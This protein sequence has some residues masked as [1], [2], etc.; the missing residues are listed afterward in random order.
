MSNVQLTEKDMADNTSNEQN[1]YK[2]WHDAK[3]H[4]C[5]QFIMRPSASRKSGDIIVAM[6]VLILS[7]SMTS[8]GYAEKN[9][10][11]NKVERALMDYQAFLENITEIKELATERLIPLLGEWKMLD[12]SVYAIVHH[13]EIHNGV[14]GNDSVYWVLRDSINGK[15]LELTESQTRTLTDYLDVILFLNE[16]ELD[17]LS[18]S[19]S[20]SAHKF[21]ASMD[22]VPVFGYDNRNTV[23]KYE[24]VLDDAL[25]KGFKSRNDVFMFL[26]QEDRAFRSFLTHLSSYGDIP[27]TN[28]RDKSSLLMKRLVELGQEENPLLTP[29]E[30][31]ILLTMRNNR[32]LLQNAVQCADDIHKMKIRNATQASAYMWMLLQPWMTF[33]KTSYALMNEEQIKALYALAAKAPE[34]ITGLG[35]PEFPIGTDE[36]ATLLINTIITNL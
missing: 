24:Q 13:A 7:L 30:I 4:F 16:T 12:D 36:L 14:T 18:R 34:C 2:G 28:I 1:L 22:V 5:I 17:S 6:A 19:F 25:Q 10:N 33:D 32:R 35:N 15:M 20:S 27:L 3:G 29:K 9:N 8:C 11:G 26:W 21:Y 23:K 31:V